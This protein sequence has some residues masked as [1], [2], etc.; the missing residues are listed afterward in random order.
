M[1]DLNIMDNISLTKEHAL[2]ARVN[3]AISKHYD[4]VMRKREAAYGELLLEIKRVIS[5]HAE[6]GFLRTTFE[7]DI[8]DIDY[9]LYCNKREIFLKKI[10]QYTE[11][12]HFVIIR[13]FNSD[14]NTIDCDF[15][16][17]EGVAVYVVHT[18]KP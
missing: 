6:I 1:K 17:I 8:F 14:Y 5:A 13:N 4:V 11:C 18:R 16:V 7:I 10:K 9:S 15:D 3:E 2:F 12:G